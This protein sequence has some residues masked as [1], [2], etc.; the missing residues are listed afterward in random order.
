MYRGAQTGEG[1][2]S[3]AFSLRFQAP[4]RTLT[5][6]EVGAI[7][8]R[9]IEAD[10]DRPRSRPAL[11]PA[12]VHVK[13]RF[14]PR[15]GRLPP[16]DALT[17][18]RMPAISLA[19]VPGRS[20]DPQLAAE[21]DRKG[22]SGI[23][24]P[25]FGDPMSL[26]LSMAHVTNEVELATSIEP[27]Y[28][29]QPPDLAAVRTCTRSA[30]SASASRHRREPRSGARAPRVVRRQAAERHPGPTSKRCAG[31]GSRGWWPAAGGARRAAHEDDGAGRRDR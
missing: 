27:I 29:R 13:S 20:A 23:W 3:L 12:A 7:R 28:F 10:P 2:R 21:I 15:A 25:S 1:R 8:Q 31:Q 26:C 30:G 16:A 14:G 6:D 4:D 11:T 22:F 19:A 17:D 18:T 24:C 5:D 9:C